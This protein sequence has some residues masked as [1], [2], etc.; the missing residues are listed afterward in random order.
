MRFSNDLVSLFSFV[1]I[2]RRLIVQIKKFLRWNR[3][4]ELLNDLCSKKLFMWKRG[5]QIYAFSSFH[6]TF[7]DMRKLRCILIIYDGQ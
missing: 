6:D 2:Y 1:R 5:L 3:Y 7:L 4:R